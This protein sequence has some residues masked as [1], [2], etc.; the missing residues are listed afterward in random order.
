MNNGLKVIGGLAFTSLISSI[1]KTGSQNQKYKEVTWDE[2]NSIKLKP[3]QFWHGI[4]VIPVTEYGGRMS[5]QDKTKKSLEFLDSS[6]YT[7]SEHSE[8]EV[9]RQQGLTPDDGTYM[10]KRASY[11]SEYAEPFFAILEIPEDKM[12]FLKIDELILGDPVFYGGYSID[13]LEQTVQSRR[14]HKRFSRFAH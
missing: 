3:N 7:V 10:S 5:E 8:H 14:K 9:K 12:E 6:G 2:L 1:V 13:V 4:S 11:V